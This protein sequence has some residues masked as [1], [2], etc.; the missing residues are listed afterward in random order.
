MAS[1]EHNRIA[2]PTEIPIP[3]EKRQLHEQAEMAAFALKAQLRRN[4][5]KT[6]KT[7]QV[8]RVLLD[9]P[10]FKRANNVGCY[11]SMKKGELQTD[12]IV[13]HLLRRGSS[14]YTPYIP[15]PP[16][17]SHNPSA[18]SPSSPAPE[19]DMKMLRLYS[20]EDLERC[21]ED[22][23]GIVDPGLERKD[24]EGGLREDVM[25]AN[26]PGLDLILI[27]GV[28]FDQECNRLGRGKAYYDRFLER[29]TSSNKPRPLLVALALFPQ[30]LPSL[31]SV[32]TTEHD[33]TL[34]AVVSPEG[35]V[36]GHP[37]SF[38]RAMSMVGRG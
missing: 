1:S 7:Q 29:Y 20:K 17:H 2:Q 4:M 22:R 15:A 27:P 35:L 9:E 18:P 21:P 6:L 31:E 36:W 19:E 11:L 10:F 32:P 23:W 28:A 34:D 37:E 16:K 14:L 8:L 24:G 38:E 12:G 26:T 30:I 25:S 33:F 3:E 13:D 5:L